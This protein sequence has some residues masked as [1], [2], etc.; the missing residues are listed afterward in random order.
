MSK[1]KLFTLAFVI[2][3]ISTAVL[4]FLARQPLIFLPVYYSG[5]EFLKFAVLIGFL[6][7]CLVYLNL[8]LIKFVKRLTSLTSG[9][10]QFYI[11]S[12]LIILQIVTLLTGYI[13]SSLTTYTA[14]VFYY[15][16]GVGNSLI[17]VMTGNLTAL[18]IASLYAKEQIR[19]KRESNIKFDFDSN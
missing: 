10:L 9:E 8:S 19:L 17:Y 11:L 7:F 14:D 5:I 4:C 15:Y 18:L 6:C 12:T 16:K 1:T 3:F 13:E 2:M